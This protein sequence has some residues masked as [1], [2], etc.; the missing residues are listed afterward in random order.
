MFRK[1]DDRDLNTSMEL[2]STRVD[3]AFFSAYVYLAQ[4]SAVAGG[5]FNMLTMHQ[6]PPALDKS[7]F[8]SDGDAAEVSSFVFFLKKQ[9]LRTINIFQNTSLLV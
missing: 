1:V 7:K 6:H 5:F 4:E 9:T 8:F 2:V 3:T